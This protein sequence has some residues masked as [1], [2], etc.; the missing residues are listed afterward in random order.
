[1]NNNGV[2]T[3][4]SKK[5]QDKREQEGRAM[6]RYTEELRRE[7]NFRLLTEHDEDGQAPW[8]KLLEPER[9][10]Y[11][12]SITITDIRYPDK[13]KRRADKTRSKKNQC[14]G[15]KHRKERGTRLWQ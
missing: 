5:E 4:R 6:L 11:V 8:N 13:R 1:M 3:N 9:V 2:K 15:D 14:R 7:L 12:D 10:L